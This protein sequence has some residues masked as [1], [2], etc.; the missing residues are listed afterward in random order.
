MPSSDPSSD[1]M[2]HAIPR[3][4]NSM[5]SPARG[6]TAVQPACQLNLLWEAP[7]LEFNTKMHEKTGLIFLSHGWKM[8]TW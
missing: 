7:H 2:M 8:I 5:I 3:H 1:G 6:Q 4:F